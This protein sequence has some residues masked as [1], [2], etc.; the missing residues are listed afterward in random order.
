MSDESLLPFLSQFDPPQQAEGSLDPLGL[1]AV[2]DALGVRLAPG[3]RERQSTP[4]YLTLALV[5]M[6]ACG[7]HLKAAG[8]AKGLPA[9]LVYEWLIVESLVRQLRGTPELHGIPGRD[10]VLAT[11]VAGDTVCIR[12][13]LK[14]PS[15]FGF[16]ETGLFDAEGNPV[17]RGYFRQVAGHRHRSGAPASAA[18]VVRN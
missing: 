12:T 9:W 15:V 6:A 2:A 16:H 4:R 11:L 10:K 8:D 1:F 14:T 7:D 18:S 3:V 17:D 13:Y 5:G